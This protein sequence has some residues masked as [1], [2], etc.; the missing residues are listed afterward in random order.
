MLPVMQHVDPTKVNNTQFIPVVTSYSQA[1]PQQYSI[2]TPVKMDEPSDFNPIVKTKPFA[3]MSPNSQTFS[4]FEGNDSIVVT[5]ELPKWGVNSKVKFSDPMQNEID[6]SLD[7]SL[8][9]I[10]TFWDE[11]EEIYIKSKELVS[12]FKKRESELFNGQKKPK[13]IIQA[14]LDGLTVSGNQIEQVM[15]RCIKFSQNIKIFIVSNL[16]KLFTEQTLEE[17]IKNIHETDPDERQNKMI[18]A[19]ADYYCKLE[20]LFVIYIGKSEIEQS[21]K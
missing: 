6:S 1:I 19:V 16:E 21:Q 2:V 15:S 7:G 14:Y 12:T 17:N 3:D 18:K 9:K 20:K 13:N 11:R 5:Q 4:K 10:R 8:T